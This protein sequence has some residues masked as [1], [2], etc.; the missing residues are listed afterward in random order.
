ML[1]DFYHLASTPLERVLPR[2]CEK[3]LEEGQRLLVVAEEPVLRQL[4]EQ[5]WTH[6]PDSFLPHGR[7]DKVAANKQ[8]ILL[9]AEVEPL[10]GAQNVALADGIWRDQA[11]SFDRTFYLFDNAHLDPAR[12]AGRSLKGHGAAEPRY[13]KQDDRG[14]W[15]QGP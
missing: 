1:V 4:D 15:V 2:I 6:A 12:G 5:L 13:W 7:S 8:P 9:S 10:N 3:L 11:L 14:K